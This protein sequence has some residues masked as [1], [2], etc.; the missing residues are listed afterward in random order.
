VTPVPPTDANFWS[1]GKGESKQAGA[2]AGGAGW[3]VPFRESASWASRPAQLDGGW[4]EARN[5]AF[6]S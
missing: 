5:V 6:N 2:S 3:L 4:E 1:I